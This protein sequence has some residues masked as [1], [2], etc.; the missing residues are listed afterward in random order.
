MGLKDWIDQT[1]KNDQDFG[2]D[3]KDN[4]NGKPNGK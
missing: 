1:V 3:G 2:R 4:P